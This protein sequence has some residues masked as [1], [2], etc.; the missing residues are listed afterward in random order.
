MSKH[1]FHGKSK[2]AKAKYLAKHPTSVY[3]GPLGALALNRDGTTAKAKNRS[4]KKSPLTAK[5]LGNVLTKLRHAGLGK[6]R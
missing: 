2:S 4:P 3:H 5:R 1:W 6:H